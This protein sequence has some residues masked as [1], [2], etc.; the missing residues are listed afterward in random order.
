LIDV[1]DAFGF[2]PPS[3]KGFLDYA[4]FGFLLH[5]LALLVESEDEIVSFISS[6]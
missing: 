1:L 5:D 4:A 3:S 2:A 6:L